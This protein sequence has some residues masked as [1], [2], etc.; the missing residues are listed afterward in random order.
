[1]ITINEIGSGVYGAYRLARR[2]P[3]G[4][5]FFDRSR[6]GALKSFF[7]A[8][9]LLPFFGFFVITRWWEKMD[10]GMVTLER[11]L[12]F[13][14][15][16]YVI[17]WTI[18]PVFMI[19][20]SRWIDRS[21]RYFDFLVASNWAAV[22]VMGIRFPGVVIQELE[23]LPEPALDIMIFT[24]IAVWLFYSWYVYKTALDIGGGLAAA[25]TAAGFFL[26]LLV[27]DVISTIIGGGT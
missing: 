10:L 22:M 15:L 20:I 19:G 23:L 13:E 9:L 26:R 5:A 24:L 21:D 12:I 4:M 18:F 25:L 2:D 3:G 6:I 1:M 17:A 27:G 7:A 16:N 14:S 11:V 8:G